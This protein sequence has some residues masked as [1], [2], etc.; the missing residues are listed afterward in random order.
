MHHVQPACV[1]A[2][3]DRHDEKLERDVLVSAELVAVVVVKVCA[4]GSA[5]YVW[6]RVLIER[7]LY[8]D[9]RAVAMRL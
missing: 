3:R 1:C 4:S 5:P 6:E 2:H 9:E 8:V 7:A